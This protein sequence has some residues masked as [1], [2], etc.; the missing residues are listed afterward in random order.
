MMWDGWIKDSIP[1]A[2]AV[3]MAEEQEELG[4]CAQTNFAQ[5]VFSRHFG[6]HRACAIRTTLGWRLVGW[7]VEH[8]GR[9][10]IT[11]AARA[12]PHDPH[13]L[14]ADSGRI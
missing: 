1:D 10:G 8:P 4:G 11:Y 7:L 12:I 6:A 13:P 9:G 3:E 2:R 14:M 5:A